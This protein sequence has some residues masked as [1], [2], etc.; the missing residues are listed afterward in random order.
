MDEI[1]QRV[2]KE[3]SQLE[4]HILHGDLHEYIDD[5]VGDLLQMF[6]RIIQ[7]AS[8]GAEQDAA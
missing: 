2:L 3:R 5:N 4:D 8:K 7:I 6:N 1:L